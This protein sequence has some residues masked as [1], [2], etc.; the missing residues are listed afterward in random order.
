VPF[1]FGASGGAT[2]PAI[3]KFAVQVSGDDGKT[4]RPA[5]V[6]PAGRGAY[7][8]VV[9]LPDGAKAVSLR[10]TATDV[11]GNSIEQTVLRAF[12]ISG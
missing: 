1:A 5:Y 9:A 3:R 2:L 7:R 12:A 6:V 11:Q 10:A 8:L 4:W